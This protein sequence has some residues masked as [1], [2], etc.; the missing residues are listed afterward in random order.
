M[1]DEPNPCAERWA[2]MSDEERAE[3]TAADEAYRRRN[4][5]WLFDED[6]PASVEAEDAA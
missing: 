2:K 1:T 3:A 6:E 5:P 4:Y